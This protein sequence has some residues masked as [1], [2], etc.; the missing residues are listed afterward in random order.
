MVSGVRNRTIDVLNTSVS[1]LMLLTVFFILL[2]LAIARADLLGAESD[3]DELTARLITQ[4]KEIAELKTRLDETKKNMGLS[5]Q[6]LDD[7][8]NSRRVRIENL[9]KQIKDISKSLA[10][11]KLQNQILRTALTA[12]ENE[13]DTLKKSVQKLNQNAQDN[14]SIESVI[15]ELKRVASKNNIDPNA[16]LEDLVRQ[17]ETK[18]GSLQGTAATLRQKL[19][20]AGISEAEAT[21]GEVITARC[22]A[23]SGRRADAAFNIAVRADGFK[24][25]QSWSKI[26]GPDARSSKHMMNL[27][28]SGF[29]GTRAFRKIGQRIRTES[30]KR[31]PPCI[32]VV[33]VRIDTEKTPSALQYKELRDVIGRY[34]Y[35]R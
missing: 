23:E 24:I 4:E 29:I 30:E 9:E 18:L 1:E 13:R 25:S 10:V 33:S 26:H 15:G 16:P 14:A 5:A 8:L 34:F 27:A 19:K 2:A 32:F 6:Q 7:A 3:R 22:W 12:A 31:N 11:S 20:S 21:E 28:K 35:I 17:L